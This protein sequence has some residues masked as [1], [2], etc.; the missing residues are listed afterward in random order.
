MV[1]KVV[2]FFVFVFCLH[3]RITNRS[4]RACAECVCVCV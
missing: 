3:A 4:L 2:A 1:E